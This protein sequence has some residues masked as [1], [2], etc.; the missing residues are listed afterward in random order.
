MYILADNFGIVINE[1]IYLYHYD[2]DISNQQ[3]SLFPWEYMDS[4]RYIGDA[5][6][7]ND[8]EILNDIKKLLI[9]DFMDKYKGY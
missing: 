9:L 1:H 2:L 6:W 8:D 5:W 7:T 4:K 3:K